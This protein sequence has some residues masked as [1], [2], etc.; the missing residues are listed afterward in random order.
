MAA[1]QPEPWL[2]QTHTDIPVVHRAVLHAL[3]QA[4]EDIEAWCKPLTLEELE[5]RPHGLPSVAFQVRH[6]AR[7]LDRLMTYAE[8][9]PLSEAQ[10]S[11]LRTESEPSP[12]KVELFA[13]FEGTL[14]RTLQRR[15]ALQSVDLN[16]PRGLG[17]AAI[18]TTVGSILIHVA[19]H[20]QRHV[21]QAITTAKVVASLR[22]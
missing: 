12:T 1:P 5:S 3:E 7:S 2:R 9:N 17:R 4:G 16:T 19:E 10:F 6:I 18:P 22:S 21:G 13:E 15:S 8:G 14:A 20:T 11:A